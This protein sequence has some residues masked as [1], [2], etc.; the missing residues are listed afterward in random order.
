MPSKNLLIVAGEASGDLHAANLLKEIKKINP[1]VHA[2]G[3]GGAKLR[4]AGCEIQHDLTE[5]AVVGFVEVMKHYGHFR[6]VFFDILEKT[7]EVKPDAAI[8]VD[9]PGFNLKLAGYLKKQGIRVIYFIS[10][11]VWAW[12]K[13][14]VHFIRKNIDLLLVLFKFEE[15]LYTDGKFQVKFVGHPLLD[16]VKA[17]KTGQAVLAE[18]GFKQ[19][20]ATISLLPG[21][22]LKEVTRLLPGMLKSAQII[23]KKMPQAQFFVCRAST[24][25]RQIIKDIIDK[26]QI[27]F[28]YKM[29]DDE[30]Y[31]GLQAS[32]FAIVASG[33]A[34][35]ETAILN[36]PMVIVYKVAWPTWILAKLFIRIPHIGLVNVVAGQ[37]IV[38]ELIQADANP[39]K[40]AKTVM[41]ILNDKKRMEKT[42]AEL[43]ALKNTLGI[44]GATQRAAE[45]VV[46]F[47][48]QPQ[49]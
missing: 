33:T 40:I 19:T 46:K 28:P 4:E 6:K 16:H 17:A 38:P 25:P 36:K 7:K 37:K 31:N 9:Y 20:G 15:I 44:P 12:G 24:I 32:D 2:F 11:Q 30:T 18:N 45:E 1:Q 41:E 21:S 3:I 8:L 29:L 34:T 27:D 23:F 39:Q 22:R 48:N 10:P 49:K 35:L 47:L 26:T 42:H 43:Y 5:L 14:R 13:E